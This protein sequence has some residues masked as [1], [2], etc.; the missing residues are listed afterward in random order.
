MRSSFF[1]ALVILSTTFVSAA[2]LPGGGGGGGGGGPPSFPKG[3]NAQSGYSGNANGGSAINIGGNVFN[4]PLASKSSSHHLLFFPS[5]S[6]GR[7][8]QTPV[9]KVVGLHPALLRVGMVPV[10]GDQHSP[11]ALAVLTVVTP[12]TMVM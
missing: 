1:A 4:A 8:L 2:P 6:F 3:G 12:L 11:A 9:A 7:S 5:S 10:E